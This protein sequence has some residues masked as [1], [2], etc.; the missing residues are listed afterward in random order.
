MRLVVGLGALAL[1]AAGCGGSSATKTVTATITQRVTVTA[2]TATAPTSETVPAKTTTDAS[3]TA[4]DDAG[5]L[6]VPQALVGN[7]THL[8]R[9]VA[10]KVSVVESG[11][12]RFGSIPVVV[13]NGTGDT[14]ARV[15]VTATARQNGA[16]VASGESQDMSPNF[17]VGRG[18]ELGYVYFST[19]PPAGSRI[20]FAVSSTKLTDDDFE[21]NR[22][23]KPTEQ[24]V[25]KGSFSLE[26]VG[27]MKNTAATKV[28]GP[29]HVILICLSKTGK[30]M[31]ESNGFTSDDNAAPGATVSYSVSLGSEDKSCPTPL[32]A[33]GGFGF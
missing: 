2:P 30:I 8:P 15:K 9:G 1:L 25:R 11:P 28:S 31:S 12:F 33:G 4:S 5:K 17:V 19:K 22:D 10:G 6:V 13:F 27:T 24:H 16:L 18:Y 20:V 14:V 3:T 23:M 29:I 32:V 7:T 21:L 26:L